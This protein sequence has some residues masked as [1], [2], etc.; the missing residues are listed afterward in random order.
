MYLLLQQFNCY[1]EFFY[2]FFII[3]LSFLTLLI[4]TQMLQIHFRK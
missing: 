1:N 3:Y 4:I 2:G